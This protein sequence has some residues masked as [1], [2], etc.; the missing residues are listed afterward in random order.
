[1]AAEKLGFRG[2]MTRSDLQMSHADARAF[3]RK[4][5]VAS[6]GTVDSAGWPYVVPLM[7][8]YEEGD[9]LYLHTGAR[10][11]HFFSNI[12]ESAK[13]CIAV[14]EPGPMHQGSPSPCNG[15][16]VYKSA[17][18]FGKVRV[19]DGPQLEEQ[20]TW[21]FDRLLERLGDARSNY[22]TGYTMLKQIT[23][24]E[25]TIEILTGKIKVGLHH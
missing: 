18:V 24:Y 16:L 15:A 21:F 25:V 17:I 6:V 23:L 4:H 8:V 2:R 12:A 20:K 19:C 1:M 22:A 14:G 13:I 5:A 9:K 11:G 7:Y 3:L 10:G